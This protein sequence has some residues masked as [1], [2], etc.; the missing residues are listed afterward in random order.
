MSRGNKGLPYFCDVGAG[1]CACGSFLGCRMDW[2]KKAAP[3]LVTALA[4]NVP[5]LAAMAA[6]DIAQVIGADDSVEAV[7]S[8]LESGAMTHEQ[9]VQMKTLDTDFQT[10]MAELGYKSL[11]DMEQI[12]ANDRANARE[13]EIKTGD[14]WTPRILAAVVITGWFVLQWYMLA[15]IVPQEMREIVIRG[16]GTLDMAV[17]LVLGYYFGSSSGSQTKDQTINRLQK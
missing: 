14:S 5:A 13:R 4:G 6:K 1:C 9:L 8:A 11:A 7:K 2:L 16:L 12:A 3:Y 15:H 17:G 10:R